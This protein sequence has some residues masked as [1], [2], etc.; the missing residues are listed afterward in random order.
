MQTV[1]LILQLVPAVIKVIQAIE[2]ALP[3]AGIGAEKLAAIRQMLE[4][5]YTGVKEV[6]PILEKVIA[7]LVEL[8]NKTGVFVKK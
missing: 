6:W 4:V 3:Q 1:L 7:I 8:F 2:E 5:A